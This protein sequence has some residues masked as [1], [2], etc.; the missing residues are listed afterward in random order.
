[1][2]CADRIGSDATDQPNHD[3][4]HRPLVRRGSARAAPPERSVLWTLN[5]MERDVDDPWERVEVI[6]K[7]RQATP[8]ELYDA[9]KLAC[10]A[11][12]A[13]L[14]RSTAIVAHPRHNSALGIS[15]RD[16]CL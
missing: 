16:T 4:R 5:A 2:T 12:L 11:V 6:A 15:R 9:A 1:M 8:V 10:R 7:R 3:R 13:G 14:R